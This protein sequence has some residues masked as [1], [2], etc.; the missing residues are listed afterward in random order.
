MQVSARVHYGC[1]AMLEL[2]SRYGQDRPVALREIAKRHGIPQP[3][4]VQILQSLRTANL[5]TSTR[6]SGGGYRL[7][8]APDQI[9]VLDIA[10]SIGCGESA[11]IGNVGDAGLPE[12]DALRGLWQRADDAA[13]EI[14]GG[15][16]LEDLVQACGDDSAAMFYI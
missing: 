6:G 1:L 7:S 9:R 5:V 14:L 15:T 16:T 3:F 2:A 4:L 13:R 11:T 10:E 12:G 8:V